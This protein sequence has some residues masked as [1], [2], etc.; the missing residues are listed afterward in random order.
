MCAGT[1]AGVVDM[2]QDG[3]SECPHPKPWVALVPFSQTHTGQQSFVVH[4]Y[5]IYDVNRAKV[6]WPIYDIPQLGVS[7]ATDADL[8]TRILGTLAASA[9]NVALSAAAEPIPDHWHAVTKDGVSLS[10]PPSW[11]IKALAASCGLFVRDSELFLV[12][13]NLTPCP[14]KCICGPTGPPVFPSIQSGVSLFETRTQPL[15]TH[16]HRTRNRHLAPRADDRRV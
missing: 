2:G 3:Q 7:I 10:I 9:S 14:G 5:R 16:P 4:G 6:S 1:S 15:R 12:T 8:G 11:M 13:P